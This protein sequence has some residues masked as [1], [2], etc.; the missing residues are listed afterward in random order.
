M[1]AA[2]NLASKPPLAFLSHCNKLIVFCSVVGVFNFVNIASN[3]S[4]YWS[5]ASKIESFDCLSYGSVL[6]DCNNCFIC[7][8]SSDDDAM[9]IRYG[10]KCYTNVRYSNFKFVKSWKCK[11]KKE[12]LIEFVKMYKAYNGVVARPV[13]ALKLCLT[14]ILTHRPISV[15]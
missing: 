4:G 5:S 3:A 13:V 7:L 12:L 6:M 9:L 15:F 14:A 11:Y 2:L 1:V 8:A 10:V